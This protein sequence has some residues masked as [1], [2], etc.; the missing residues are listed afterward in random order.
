MEEAALAVLGWR[1]AIEKRKE[2]NGHGPATKNQP[3][4]LRR[5]RFG[6]FR[7]FSQ[8]PKKWQLEVV[9]F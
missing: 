7:F 1:Q 4:A 5:E 3:I 8:K 9:N 6:T 2:P